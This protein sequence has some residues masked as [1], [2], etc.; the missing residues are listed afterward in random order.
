MMKKKTMT[1]V[2]MTT[3]IALFTAL[4][5][6][7]SVAFGENVGRRAVKETNFEV[8]AGD[9]IAF[10]AVE[11]GVAV[12][13]FDGWG[14][15]AV[16]KKPLKLDG[17]KLSMSGTVNA[18]D[19]F[20]I[21]FAN[22][23]NPDVYFGEQSA[24]AITLWNTRY[25][26]QSRLHFG[27][28][29]N[30]DG[31]VRAYQDA[32]CTTIGCG[33]ADSMVLDASA[34]TGMEMTFAKV[35][36]EAY[37]VTVKMT[38]GSMW[39]NNANYDSEAKT[40]TVYLKTSEIS[41][42]L[43]ENGNVY[44]YV[45]GF[46]S[47]ENPP[48]TVTVNFEDANSSGY[49]A[50]KTAAQDALDAYSQAI[51]NIVD[52]ITYTAAATYRQA[53]ADAISVLEEE[54]KAAYEAQLKVLDAKY[55]SAMPFASDEYQTVAGAIT[56]TFSPASGY[57]K[58]ANFTGWG[59]RA[60]YAYK[61][62]LDGLK[63]SFKTKTLSGD[64][65]GFFL[66]NNFGTSPYFGDGTPVAVTYWN[67][68]YS[69]QARLNFGR[70]HDYNEDSIVY[71]SAEC[72]EKGFG[73]ASSMVASQAET[74]GY[75][76][77]FNKQ[78]ED[79]YSVTVRMLAGSMWGNNA[80]Y[81]DVAKTCTV[82]LKTAD[83]GEV[84]DAEGYTYVYFA[85][86]PSAGNSNPAFDMYAKVEDADLAAYKADKVAAV[87]TKIE[88]YKTA[89]NAVV[90]GTTFDASLAAREGVVN[91]IEELRPND[92]V[93]YGYRLAEADELYTKDASVQANVKNAIA[94][95]FTIAKEKVDAMATD[96]GATEANL[97]ELVKAVNAAK[98]NLDAKRSM[99]TAE[100]QQ[101]F[102]GLVTEY[103]YASKYATAR[104]W[105][106]SYETKINAINPESQ[107]VIADITAVKEYKETYSGSAVEN[108]ITTQLTETDKATLEGRITAADTELNRLEALFSDEVKEAYLVVLEEAL[109]EDLTLKAN[110]DEAKVAYADLISKVSIDENNALYQR[111]TDAY[112]TLKQACADYLTAEIR[113]VTQM[114]NA[115][116]AQLSEFEPV[117]IRYAQIKLDY[118]MEEDAGVAGELNELKAKIEKHAFYYVST[119][120]ID[121]VTQNATGLYFEQTPAFP[122]RLNYEKQLNLVK[123]VKVV[124]Q[125]TEAAFYNDGSKANNLCFNF[126]G[127]KG[128]YKSMSDGISIIIWL[129]PTESNVQIFNNSDTALASA[130]IATPMDGANITIEIVYGDYYD[131]V[132]DTTYKAYQIKVNEATI[133]LTPETLTQYGYEVFND[134][135]FSMGSF[136]DVK[137]NPNCFTLV[138]VN[139]FSFA[140]TETKPDPEK[141][142]PEKPD[143]ESPNPESPNPE[144]PNPGSSDLE[145]QNPEKPNKKKGCGA[146]ASAGIGGVIAI[147]AAAA[148]V[149]KK[150]K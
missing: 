22:S 46:P 124:V 134:C 96:E 30:P 94:E 59:A 78:S 45:A 128:S 9:N 131:F 150:R 142:D 44:A 11:D 91:A 80:N 77:T 86:F 28:D 108:I 90:D 137:D 102:D 21:I 125:M 97:R 73:V 87:E 61:V 1:I 109:E 95:L 26:G 7:F 69:G 53:V 129:Y 104:I 35:S 122:S 92:K 24:L 54:D 55:A 23:V 70:S 3:L 72:T 79:L 50:L 98:S 51:D 140:K 14:R 5:V 60:A 38:A 62:K 34:T 41:S 71:T 67:S 89:I 25:T 6:A 18:G 81:D 47:G 68:L 36:D 48:I 75:E 144:S 85:G 105:V 33:V 13:G 106:V 49:E 43:D 116:Y 132:Q 149:L 139:D 12:S 101:Y 141:P 113:A 39:T 19:C 37:S 99:L 16:Y 107:T 84:F 120:Q 143:P 110:I 133:V 119:T 76:I 146:A 100:N 32:A 111:F 83:I 135:Y 42:I 4:N 31:A 126:L 8:M 66:A 27:E 138:S 103:E 64:C 57:T 29:H 52:D 136:A 117:R 10:A 130:T 148:V 93:V 118:L 112:K 17:L 114:L 56:A 147:I 115:T 127:S 63:V 88:E 145:S 123:G 74:M 121:S 20:G 82:Y 65:A 15:R 58:L 2:V 40:S